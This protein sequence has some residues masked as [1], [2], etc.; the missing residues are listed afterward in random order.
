MEPELSMTMAILRSPLLD[1]AKRLSHVGGVLARGRR[2]D[3]EA[4]ETRRKKEKV[5][6]RIVVMD[7]ITIR[8]GG[9]WQASN[10]EERWI[11]SI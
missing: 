3:A 4:L 5:A 11:A 1:L 9:G 2:A 8:V 10:P 6:D 7:C